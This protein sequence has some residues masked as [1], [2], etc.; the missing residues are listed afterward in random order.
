MATS[1]SEP[2][3]AMLAAAALVGGCLLGCT[4]VHSSAVRTGTADY[5]PYQGAVR[6]TAF[7]VPPKAEQVAVVQVAGP[8]HVDE[9]IDEFVQKTA[10]VGADLGVIDRVSTKFEL[11]TRTESYSYSCGS[12]KT[13]QTCYGTR[14]V[15]E[16]VGTTQL[17]GRAFRTHGESR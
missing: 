12:G 10:E 14:T 3:L 9:L 5:A 11:V 6:I 8:R 4:G 1:S 16:E 7:Y 17:L 15:T 2:K 13:T